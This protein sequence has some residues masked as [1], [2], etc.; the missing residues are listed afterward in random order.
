MKTIN[1]NK[2]WGNIKAEIHR[3]KPSHDNIVTREALFGLQIILS[4]YE[5]A[6][7]KKDEK[8]M[9]FCADI[10]ETYERYDINGHIVWGK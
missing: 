6:K 3:I 2:T 9:K 8:L 1:L 7:N 5:L 10:L 4:Q